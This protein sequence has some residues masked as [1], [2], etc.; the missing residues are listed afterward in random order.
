MGN[1]WSCSACG[2]KLEAETDTQ[3]GGVAP[4]SVLHLDSDDDAA[5]GSLRRYLIDGKL[6]FDLSS[7]FVL[8]QCCFVC[9]LC[10]GFY[11]RVLYR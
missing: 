8:L 4:D 7:W 6:C 5:N 9:V 2:K 10:C 1:F 3:V 11:Y